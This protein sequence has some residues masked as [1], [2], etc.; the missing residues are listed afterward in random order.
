MIHYFKDGLLTNIG[1][2]VLLFT[3]IL[4]LIS[5]I[6]FYKCGYNLIEID[7]KDILAT[8]VKNNT[9]ITKNKK[10]KKNIKKNKN[11]IK[12]CPKKKCCIKNKKIK[13]NFKK[14]RNNLKK[15]T[16]NQS[17]N[18]RDIN[19]CSYSKIS[20]NKGSSVIIFRKNKK[21]RSSIHKINY[22]DKDLNYLSYRDA[23]G[24]DKRE[25]V[26]FYFSF[27]KAKHP[28]IFSFYPHK[29]YNLL[30]VKLDLFFLFFIIYYFI[31]ALF[32]NEEAIHKIYEDEGIYNI[33]YFLPK[34]LFSFIISHFICSL[35]KYFSL[36]E[37]NLCEIKINVTS[38][39]ISDIVKKEKNK[40]MIKYIIFY[41]LSFLFLMFLWYYLS[42]FNAVY[43][44]TQIYVIKNSLISFSISFV[45][46]FFIIIFIS[47]FRRIS[48]QNN[49]KECLYQMSQFLSYL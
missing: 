18:S 32:F 41:V 20:L 4:F 49:D 22:I 19:L 12:A 14:V 40:L 26:Q 15:K 48:L 16:K 43:K 13:D 2:Y 7:I 11:T 21:K 38:R 10:I 24:N 39:I 8:K 28:L 37:R 29:D 46:P 44:N 1:S 17:I 47:Y 3:F 5:G 34:I 35:I 23:I 33:G 6:V 9:I 42:S 27:L 25:F 45:Y 36:S 30:V 31:N